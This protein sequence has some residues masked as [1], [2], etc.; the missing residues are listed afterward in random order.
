MCVC[1]LLDW[2]TQ[3]CGELMFI[4]E[5][6]HILFSIPLFQL[7]FH[8]SSTGPPCSGTYHLG[9]SIT[10]AFLQ[11]YLAQV[12]SFEYQ[13][14]VIAIDASSHHGR[15]TDA[16]AER[17]KKHYMAKLRRSQYG[18]EFSKVIIVGLE[19]LMHSHLCIQNTSRLFCTFS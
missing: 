16:R 13:L 1:V 8:W 11:G 19:L 18:Y 14:S 7:S 9:G 5:R 3:S 6:S 10:F 4:E 15:I 2:E 12:L 17:I